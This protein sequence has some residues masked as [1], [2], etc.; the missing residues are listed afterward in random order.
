MLKFGASWA[1]TIADVSTRPEFQ[2]ATVRLEDPNL[3]VP[4]GEYDIETG[5]Q[6]FT[7]DPVIYEGRARIIGVRWGVESGG[8]SQANAKTLKAVRIQFPYNAVERVR[9]SF[10]LYVTD[11]GRNPV[12]ESY[13]FSS[14]SDI[15]GSNSAARTIEFYTDSDIAVGAVT[16][17]TSQGYGRVDYG[18]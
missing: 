10:N 3:L 9:K 17:Y 7:G 1:Q 12:L 14:A 2:N 11:G 6:E 13:M 16:G 15:Q 18:E 5:T 4:T 8:E